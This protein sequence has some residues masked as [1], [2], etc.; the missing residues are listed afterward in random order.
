MAIISVNNLSKEFRIEKREKGF[1]GLLTSLFHKDVEI[2]RVVNNVSFSIE[3][4]E[5]VGLIGPNGAGKSTL[6]KMLCGI[7]HPTEGS[8]TIESYS[9]QKDRKRVVAKLGVVFGQRTQLYWDLRLGESFELLKRIYNIDNET[10]ERNMRIMNEVFEIDK[11]IDI[12]VRQLSLGQ[13]MRGDFAAAMLHSPS[14]LFLDEPTIGLDIEAKYAIRKLIKDINQK[15]KTT[16]LLT[17]HDIGDVKEL[18]D[19]LIVINGGKIVAD[20]PLKDI[21]NTIAPYRFLIIDLGEEPKEFYH[22]LVQVVKKKGFRI[23]VHIEKS[24][25]VAQIIA[26]LFA[27]MKIHDISIREPDI[28]DVIKELYK[29]K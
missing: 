21:M 1:I 18:C 4:G 14:I 3:K 23:W 28:E 7:L 2:K 22:P 15:W 6:V 11:I 17:T 12:P 19:R 25:N 9:P 26:E 20:G 8:I 13:R 29:I 24:A 5:I 16:V 10:F 27:R